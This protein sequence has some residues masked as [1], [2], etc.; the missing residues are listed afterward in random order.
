MEAV[1][2]TYIYYTKQAPH[3][4]CRCKSMCCGHKKMSKFN[5]QIK[6]EKI[7]IKAAQK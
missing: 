1:G 7:Y 4:C 2:V 3:R 6:Y 5:I